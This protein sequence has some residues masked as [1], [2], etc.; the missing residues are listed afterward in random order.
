[1]QNSISPK[2]KKSLEPISSDIELEFT[3]AS[4]KEYMDCIQ[5]LIDN[6]MV[7]SLKNFMQHR[8][9]SRLNHSLNVS[10]ISYF[11]C[12]KWGL[13]YISAAR[14]GLL[15][16][17]FLY[18][19]HEKKTKKLYKGMH[20]MAHPRV[21]LRNANKYFDLNK[22][23][24]DIIRKHMWP[25]TISFPKYR[26]SYVIIAVDKYCAVA[27]FFNKCKL[28]KIAK[29]LRL[30]QYINVLGV[31]IDLDGKQVSDNFFDLFPEIE[32]EF[33]IHEIEGVKYIKCIFACQ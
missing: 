9:I 32:K 3:D 11:V 2:L 16:D 12:R 26:E 24:K 33:D 22:R 18:N 20:G 28:K 29:I 6:E 25:L 21:A 10:Y 5:D 13:D 1:M 19:W 23:E 7:I 31:S 15:H 17:F 4:I 14:G 27:E 8:G 30:M